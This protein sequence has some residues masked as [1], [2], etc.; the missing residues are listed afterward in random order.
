MS[1]LKSPELEW[2]DEKTP[3]SGRFDDVY[4]SADDGV[5]ESQYVFIDG[6]GL[7]DLFQGRDHVTIAETGFG[8]GLNFL[9]TLKAWRDCQTDCALHYISVE[10][11]PLTKDQLRAAYQNFVGLDGLYEELLSVYPTL[12]P[13]FHHLILQG[14]RVKLTL[15]LGEAAEMLADV[16]G[17]VDAWYLDGFAPKKNPD[18]WRADVF[19]QMA[20]LSRKGTVLTTFTAAGFVKRGL[21]DV[22]FTMSKRKGFGRKRECLQGVFEGEVQLSKTKWYARSYDSVEPKKIAVIGA[23]VAGLH[24]AY[25]LKADG[26]DVTVFERNTQAGMEGSGNRI[27]LIKPKLFLNQKGPARFNTIAYLHALQF[28]DGFDHTPWHGERGLFQMA[29]DDKDDDHLK[30]LVARDIL[31]TNDLMYLSAEEA[32]QRL[33]MEVDRGGLWYPRSGCVEPAPL[34]REIAKQL[35]V[36]YDCGITKIE[37]CDKGWQLYQDDHVLFDGDCVV[38]AT[39]GENAALNNYC[40]LPML[41]RRGQVSYLKPNAHSQSLRHAVSYGGYLL[42]SKEG[43]HIVGASFEHWPDF[44]DHAYEDVTQAS[45][46]HNLKILSNL[47]DT[48]DLELTGGRASIRAMTGDHL[49]MVGPVFSKDWY[50]A[51]Y[52][53]LKHGPRAK[54]FAPAEYIDGLYAICGLGARGVQTA[55]LLADILSSYIAG[56]PCP[57]ENTIREALHP[58]RFLMRDIIKGKI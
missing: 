35:D 23:G 24:S 32:S 21:A 7:P 48:H 18:M 28:Y 46:D 43:E 52:E 29:K 16:D 12:T 58:A 49:P 14:G 3:V 9:L 27:G 10:G 13:G 42:P 5:A 56:T 22:G 44:Y 17:K 54:R 8:T 6:C 11:F 4:F 26:H 33:A 55:P 34:C 15:L 57:V 50:V 31:P 19:E 47:M 39:A 30:E 51:E 37:K 25:R 1:D 38:I 45:H 36:R 20:R 40:D 2:K 53:R 41:G